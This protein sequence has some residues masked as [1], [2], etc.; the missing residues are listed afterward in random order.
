MQT[1]VI[2][3]FLKKKKEKKKEKKKSYIVI[4]HLPLL[5]L[6]LIFLLLYKNLSITQYAF[7]K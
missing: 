1:H 3:F 4:F 5:D 7:I 2:P 6:Y